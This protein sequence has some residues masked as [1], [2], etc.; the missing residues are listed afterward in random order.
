MRT[1][2]GKKDFIRRQ[3]GGRSCEEER[4]TVYV[5]AWRIPQ[6]GG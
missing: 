1:F 5:E 6:D 2:T 3:L 4:A